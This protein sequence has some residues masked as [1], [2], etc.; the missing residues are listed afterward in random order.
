MAVN[1]PGQAGS[2]LATQGRALPFRFRRASPA[3]DVQC[4]SLRQSGPRAGP[5]GTE[6]VDERRQGMAAPDRPVAARREKDAKRRHNAGNRQPWGASPDPAAYAP[7]GKADA[8]GAPRVTMRPKQSEG[9]DRGARCPGDIQWYCQSGQQRGKPP[10]RPRNRKCPSHEAPAPV[11][12][13]CGNHPYAKRSLLVSAPLIRIKASASQVHILSP[14][15]N[16]CKAG[17]AD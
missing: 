17:K 7:A 6:A 15:S 13:M 16:G 2:C 5:D 3:S 12:P 1:A 4:P 10:Q 14:E 11:V 9:R 8:R